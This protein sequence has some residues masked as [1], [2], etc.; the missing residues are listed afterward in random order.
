MSQ[1]RAPWIAFIDDDEK[2]P[3]HWVE[4][5][6]EIIENY[7]PDIFGGPYHP[8][9]VYPKPIWFKDHYLTLTLGQP[10]GWVE[11]D[12]HLFG[13]NIVFK[14]SWFERLQGY[15]TK[16][17]RKG[18]NK[19]YGENAEIELRAHRQGARF[20][21][22]RDLYVFHYVQAEQLTAA[23]FLSSAWYHGKADAKITAAD[24]GKSDQPVRDATSKLGKFVLN[25]FMVA[26]VYLG[27][28]FRNRKTAPFS[29]N[30]LAQTVAPSISVLATSWYLF[31]L[32][33]SRRH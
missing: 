20:Y 27:L 12:T 11:S 9:Y 33:L 25:I 13:G 3:T 10:K 31:A 8:Y 16:L 14:R 26:G 29:E 22:D 1:A 24:E 17:G 28:P 15:S 7:Q 19:E 32:S 4:K 5:A 18:N 21:F 6:L 2:L 23:W 30:Y